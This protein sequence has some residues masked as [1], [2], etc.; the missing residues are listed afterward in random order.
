MERRSLLLGLIGEIVVST[1]VESSLSNSFVVDSLG[2][3]KEAM[4]S[5][6]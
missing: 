2:N 3:S 4:V 1:A 6:S 5:L